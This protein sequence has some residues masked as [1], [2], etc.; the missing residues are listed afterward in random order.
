[1]LRE[2]GDGVQVAVP[3]RMTALLEAR[4]VGK[5]LWRR[6][7]RRD[8]TVAL[9]DFSLP[10]DADK[11]SITAVVGES[12]SGKTTLARLLLGLVT[13]TP[14][15]VLYRGEG[16]CARCRG[17]E[18][19]R[20]PPRRAGDLSG[21]VRGLQSVLSRRS[22]ADDAGARIPPGDFERREARD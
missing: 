18:R 4:R 2:V 13:P 17:A 9:D 10:I 11:P 22:C 6:P 20:V 16:P 3:F 8:R 12:G 1:M 21:S 5:V 7:D 14:G 15:Q 19:P